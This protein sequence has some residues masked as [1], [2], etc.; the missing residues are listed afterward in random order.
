MSKLRE[1][2]LELTTDMVTILL[3]TL[4]TLRDIVDD[5]E[6]NRAESAGDDTLLLA[7]LQSLT[8]GGGLINELEEDNPVA[9]GASPA[10]DGVDGVVGV[11]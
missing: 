4:D 6:A 7:N 10:V 9:T 8:V 1:K 2:S 11:D 5:I 3:R